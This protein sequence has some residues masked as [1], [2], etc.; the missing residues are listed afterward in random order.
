MKMTDSFSYNIASVIVNEAEKI[1]R[2]I[3]FY[4][5]ENGIDIKKDNDILK[6][7]DENVNVLINDCVVKAMYKMFKDDDIENNVFKYNVGYYFLN[8]IVGG[9]N[10][11]FCLNYVY[12][13]K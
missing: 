13:E 4:C 6:C 10:E 12:E 8:G 11:E 3:Y 5:K 2:N 1:G 9:F 7:L